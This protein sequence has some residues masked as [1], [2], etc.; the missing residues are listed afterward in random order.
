MPNELHTDDHS[1]GPHL[2]N[3]DDDSSAAIFTSLTHEEALTARD[4]I[5]ASLI[6]DVETLKLTVASLQQQLA[7]STRPI[8]SYADISMLPPS[9]PN[10]KRI[11]GP[12]PT[13]QPKAEQILGK[14]SPTQLRRCFNEQPTPVGLQVVHIDGYRHIRGQ[15]PA[16]FAS[17]L[18]AKFKFP[19][20][21]VLNVSIVTDRLVE[22]VIDAS[23][24][25]QLKTALSITSCPLTLFTDLDVSV[26]LDDIKT[27]EEIKTVFERRLEKEITT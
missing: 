25:D 20:K 3:S 14:L 6:A 18:E 5:I 21:H 24:L 4:R 22:I 26:P 23:T 12:S 1:S 15:N 19:R 10:T 13:P 8:T 11:K 7:A 9:E 16:V 27:V 17:I 2:T